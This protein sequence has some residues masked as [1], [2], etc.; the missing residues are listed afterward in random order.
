MNLSMQLTLLGIPL[1]LGGC[2]NIGTAPGAGGPYFNNIPVGST[3]TL[4]QPLVIRAER[5]RVWL[6]RS[7]PGAAA[8][9]YA[10]S[11]SLELWQRNEQR[12][13]VEP[14]SFVIIRISG[15][16]T[17]ILVSIPRR[18]MVAS[19]GYLPRLAQDGDGS[20]FLRSYADFYLKSARQP[21]VY[22]VS[23]G[24]MDDPWEVEPLTI[25]EIREAL[26]GVMVLDLKE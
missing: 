14:D 13:V 7:G 11:C 6:P 15:G 10:T 12:V 2:Q 21:D 4:T 19:Y 24:Y 18:T 16:I 8:G 17:P 3:L 25:A 22:R 1:L 9:G 5:V 26:D 20:S 23:C